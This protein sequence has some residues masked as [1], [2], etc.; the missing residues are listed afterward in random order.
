MTEKVAEIVLIQ[1]RTL[2]LYRMPMGFPKPASLWSSCWWIH[3]LLAVQDHRNYK[4]VFGQWWCLFSQ[5]SCKTLMMALLDLLLPVCLPVG[6]L[7]ND[8][9]F[10]QVCV[11]CLETAA[12]AEVIK[13]RYL[14]L[15]FTLDHPF[16]SPSYPL[17]PFYLFSLSLI[18]SVHPFLPPIQAL[19]VS[20]PLVPL[21][22]PSCTT[23]GDEWIN[24]P[25]AHTLTWPH[26]HAAVLTDR[27][28]GRVFCCH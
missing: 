10:R 7:A 12:E 14:N 22:L 17:S 4:S 3:L 24:K 23:L 8:E 15:S 19:S 9:S 13:Q 6:S 20:T 28:S 11:V 25:H 18:I 1:Q 5:G 16:I 26:T 2:F 27:R 21:S